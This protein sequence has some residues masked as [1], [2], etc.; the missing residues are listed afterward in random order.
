[1][2]SIVWAKVKAFWVWLYHWITVVSGIV[3]G[4]ISTGADQLDA[5]TGV[6]F[7]AFFTEQTALR[8]VATIAM[9]K[10]LVATVGSMRKKD[11]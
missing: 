3:V 2:L 5:W 11:A 6:D 10:A 4:A 9:L 7:K 8:I 1:M